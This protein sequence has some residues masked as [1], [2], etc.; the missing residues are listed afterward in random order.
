MFLTV[1]LD[2]ERRKHDTRRATDLS[3]PVQLVDYAM[4]PI[5]PTTYIE[6]RRMVQKETWPVEL[7]PNTVANWPWML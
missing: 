7:T 2:V 6:F 1:V 5:P 3:I 4:D